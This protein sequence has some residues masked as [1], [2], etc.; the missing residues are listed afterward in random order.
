MCTNDFLITVHK[1][2]VLYLVGLHEG[3]EGVYQL[4]IYDLIF[5]QLVFLQLKSQQF[6][7]FLKYS[8]IRIDCHDN[9]S[10]SFQRKI[11]T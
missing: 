10:M 11:F 1:D 2:L 9:N 5:Q 3:V 4:A 6:L 7:R 8:S